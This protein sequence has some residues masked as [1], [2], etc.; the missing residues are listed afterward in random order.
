MSK[1]EKKSDAERVAEKLTVEL[2]EKKERA[3]ALIEAILCTG[4][5]ARNDVPLRVILE[6]AHGF[7]AFM[8]LP[9]ARMRSGTVH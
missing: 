7:Y 8:T 3:A 9:E 4:A 6:Y 5:R 1:F 2:D